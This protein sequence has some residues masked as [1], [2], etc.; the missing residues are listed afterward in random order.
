MEITVKIEKKNDN[1][2]QRR[3]NAGLSQSQLAKLAGV[4]VRV[5]QNYEQG[6]RDISKAQLS[7]LL[8]ICKVL[9]CKLSD[10]ITDTETME[11]LAEYEK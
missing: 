9:N 6:V 10:I 2:K 1:L 7:T 8:R 11:L 3:E 4:G 5:Y